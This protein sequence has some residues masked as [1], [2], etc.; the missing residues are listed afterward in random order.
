MEELQKVQ[1]SLDAGL[2]EMNMAV[3]AKHIYP[4][5]DPHTGN[6][7]VRDMDAYLIRQYVIGMRMAEKLISK[8]KN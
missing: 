8:V 2:D 1:Q 3:K 7:V 6:Y 5:V 4:G